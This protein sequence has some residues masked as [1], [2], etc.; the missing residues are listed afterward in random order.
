M[1]KVSVV[2]TKRCEEGGNQPLFHFP[3]PLWLYP[4]LAPGAT[5]ETPG[6]SVPSRGA[7]AAP[8]ALWGSSQSREEAETQCP[9]QGTGMG[10]L[11][12]AP[13]PSSRSTRFPSQTNTAAPSVPATFYCCFTVLQRALREH[14]D[15]AYGENTIR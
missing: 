13:T 6:P 1:S 12:A 3:V 15:W 11:G 7:L 4:C 9:H 8:L 2:G 5:A 10:G 14:L